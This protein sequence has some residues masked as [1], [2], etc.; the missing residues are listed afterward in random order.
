MSPP[1]APPGSG[2]GRSARPPRPARGGAPQP[3]AR[4]RAGGVFE[5]PAAAA[6]RGGVKDAGA[7]GPAPASAADAL[8]RAGKPQRAAF[9]SMTESRRF[10]RERSAVPVH[11]VCISHRWP[12][13]IVPVRG[14]SGE[15]ALLACILA[16]PVP[17][18]GQ[19]PAGSVLSAQA[20]LLRS[21]PCFGRRS[22]PTRCRAL[23][24]RSRRAGKRESTSLG[25]RAEAT[26]TSGTSDQNHGG[27]NPLKNNATFRV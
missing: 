27:K 15:R 8:A 18:C 16:W 14:A 11:R 10:I 17:D 24:S 13:S 12:C 4:A 20:P 3:P 25:L 23:R 7:R 9:S 6:S 1:A 2:S 26:S 21:G 5:P 22:F 19:I